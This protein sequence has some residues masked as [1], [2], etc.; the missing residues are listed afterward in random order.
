MCPLSKQGSPAANR[1]LND[2]R[3]RRGVDHIHA[4]GPRVVGEFLVATASHFNGFEFITE[5]LEEYRRLHGEQRRITHANDWPP[6]PIVA[7][8][9]FVI[10]TGTEG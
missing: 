7:V 5:L 6:L 2:P 1:M 3:F 9:D 10:S 8:P 4:L